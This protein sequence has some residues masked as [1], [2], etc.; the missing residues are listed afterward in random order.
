[1]NVILEFI[2][3]LT[4]SICFTDVVFFVIRKM[5]SFSE[6]LINT[7]FNFGKVNMKKIKR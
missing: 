2:F 7:K 1:M 6:S 5:L 4:I 3:Y